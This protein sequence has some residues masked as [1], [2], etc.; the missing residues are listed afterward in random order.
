MKP[1]VPV[2]IVANGI[3]FANNHVI[4]I[5]PTPWATRAAGMT[6]PVVGGIYFLCENV[7][8]MVPPDRTPHA[9]IFVANYVVVVDF[10]ARGGTL[11]PGEIVC[12]GSDSAIII[13]HIVVPDDSAY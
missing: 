12:Q 3:A 7:T 8:S 6:P 2:D 1:R 13:Q 5:N 9:I 10:R 11:L 4:W